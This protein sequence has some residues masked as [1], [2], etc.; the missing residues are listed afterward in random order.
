ML[1]ILDTVGIE[2]ASSTLLFCYRFFCQVKS[3]LR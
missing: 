2:E 3:R 1:N